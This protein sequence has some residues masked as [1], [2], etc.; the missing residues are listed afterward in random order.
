MRLHFY[1][2]YFVD[3]FA[4]T[5]SRF[6]VDMDFLCDRAKLDFVLPLKL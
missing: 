4:G 6:D 2:E 3:N 5:G 1:A